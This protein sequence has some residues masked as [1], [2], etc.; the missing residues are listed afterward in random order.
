MKVADFLDM[1]GVENL[2]IENEYGG[3]AE[4]TLEADGDYN[5]TGEQNEFEVYPKLISSVH[6]YVKEKK[7]AALKF[8]GFVQDMDLVYDRMI[9]MGNKTWPEDTYI[10][11]SEQLYVRKEIHEELMENETY[12]ETFAYGN[13]KRE[14]NLKKAREYKNNKRNEIRQKIEYERDLERAKQLEGQEI[15][16]TAGNVYKIFRYRKH[17]VILYKGE[18]SNNI[19]FAIPRDDFNAT[20]FNGKPLDANKIEDIT[21]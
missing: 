19:L 16:D 11:F 5:K 17:E 8:Y 14:N 6:H 2:R 21:L 18:R 20:A 1:L 12:A 3:I 10:P 7:P 9:K 15:Q 13:E 4:I